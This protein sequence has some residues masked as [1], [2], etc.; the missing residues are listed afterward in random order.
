MKLSTSLQDKRVCVALSGG[1]DSVAL[2]HKLRAVREAQG[3]TLSAVHCEHGIRGA[4]SLADLAFVKALCGEWGI[5]LFVFSEDCVLAAKEKSFSLE[6]AGREFRYR[7]FAEILDGGKADFIALAH[8]LDDEAETVLFRL[9]RGSALAGAGAMRE[10]NG[11]FLRPLLDEKKTDILAYVARHGL[12]YCEDATNAERIATRN[13]LRLDVLPA[14]EE[15]VAGAKE[16]LARFAFLAQEDEAFLSQLAEAYVTE[17]DCEDGADTGVRVRLCE[18][19]AL[20]RRA[21]ALALKRIGVTKDYTYALIEGVATLV[22]RQTGAKTSLPK[23]FYAVRSYDEIAFYRETEDGEQPKEIPYREGAFTWGRYEISVSK[24]PTGKVGELRFDGDKIPENAVFRA[25]RTGDE[26][27]K[28]GGGKKPLKKFLIDKKIPHALRDMPVL[29]SE[30]EVLCVCGV[31][32]SELLK[33]TDTT[34]K[35][36]Y[37]TVRRGR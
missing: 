3:F 16:N 6:T 37:L 36:R 30:N 12:R 11:R 5:P 18:E 23:G 32:I 15:A 27:R 22:E 9:A 8:H 10:E 29:A 28:F 26:F 33:V 1:A 20:L 25:R 19:R 13:V 34:E 17:C 7:V 2:L 4:E 21:C 24:T 14:L 35:T 31:E